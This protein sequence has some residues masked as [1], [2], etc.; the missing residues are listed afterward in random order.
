MTNVILCAIA[1]G[2]V[3]AGILVGVI[4]WKYK[5]KLKSPIYPIDKYAALNLGVADDRHID[6]TVT[7]VR[8]ASRKKR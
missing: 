1:A 3:A 4:I 7:R 2:L 5:T 8:V 6:T